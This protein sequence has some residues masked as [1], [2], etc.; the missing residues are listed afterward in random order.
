MLNVL[1]HLIFFFFTLCLHS[2]FP[3]KISG[4]KCLIEEKLKI[5]IVHF[6]QTKQNQQ[7]AL[8]III[9]TS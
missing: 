1:H 8:G 9:L 7:I 5:I 6:T 3:L 2:T 4:L